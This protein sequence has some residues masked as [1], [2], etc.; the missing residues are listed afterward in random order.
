MAYATRSSRP[1]DTFGT[2]CEYDYPIW[3]VVYRKATGIVDFDGQHFSGGI[4][5]PMRPCRKA[6][7]IAELECDSAHDD[8]AQ[9]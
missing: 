2:S 3:R 6:E 4:N 1:A 9:E 7:S 8:N 5:E